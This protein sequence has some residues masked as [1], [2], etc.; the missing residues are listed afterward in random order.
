LKDYKKNL[1]KNIK[2]SKKKK[3]SKDNIKM[4]SK[5]KEKYNDRVKSIQNTENKI[6]ENRRIASEI[7]KMEKEKMNSYTE[8]NYESSRRASGLKERRSHGRRNK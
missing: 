6:S 2:R 5:F 7:E 3:T 4:T 8:Y 1:D